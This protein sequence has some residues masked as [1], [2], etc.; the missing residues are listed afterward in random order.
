MRFL[1]QNIKLIV[2]TN[3]L[4]TTNPVPVFKGQSVHHMVCVC[5]C[6]SNGQ[7]HKQYPACSE[8]GKRIITAWNAQA[9]SRILS[10]VDRPQ[11]S[12]PPAKGQ[13]WSGICGTCIKC[14][15]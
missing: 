14:A 1:P 7:Q 3:S 9:D 8:E 4:L 11:E 2:V 5:P 10:K 12:G 15:V 6:S 13:E